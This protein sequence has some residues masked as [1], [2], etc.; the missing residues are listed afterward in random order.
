M[1]SWPWPSSDATDKVVPAFVAALQSVQ[2]VA[3]NKAVNA[4]NMRYS[5]AE[6]GAVL[7]EAKPELTAKGLALT[8]AATADG[9]HAVLMHS[10]GQWLAF[11]PLLVST[12][13]NTPQGQGSALTYAR[14]YQMLA[15]LNIA[16]EDDD[17]KAAAKPTR[18]R[19]QPAARPAASPA[20]NRVARDTNGGGITQAQMRMIRALYSG[21]GI[22]D[23]AQQKVETARHLG[24]A[25][26]ES[27]SNLTK[28]EASRV[29]E[30]EK[31]QGGELPLGAP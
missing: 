3:R 25:S 1:T 22:T 20:Q 4:G 29:I 30:A 15:L 23:A 10:S 28:N 27:H 19:E 16:T 9:V 8:Q 14:R 7:D 31:M 26:I 2:D 24:V 6:L 5:Y 21:R 11:P 18:Q 17:G 12:S 13:Q